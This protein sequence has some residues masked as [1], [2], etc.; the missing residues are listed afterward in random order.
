MYRVQRELRLGKWG[1]I[2]NMQM[3]PAGGKYKTTGHKYK[4]VYPM[5]LWYEAPI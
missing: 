4:M 5:K 2:E 3:T 1:V